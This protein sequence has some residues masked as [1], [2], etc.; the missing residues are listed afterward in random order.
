M[1]ETETEWLEI[2]K[3]VAPQGLHGEVRVLSASDFPERFLEPGQRWLRSPSQSQPQAIEL[4]KG[5][6]VPGK[7]LYVLQL[8]GVAN[9]NQAEAL[10]GSMLLVPASDR[11]PLDEGEFHVSD[12][13]GL[14]VIHHQT[15]AL[16]GTVV[17]VF[18]SSQDILEVQLAHPP[19]APRHKKKRRKQMAKPATVLIPFV[20]VIVPVVDLAQQRLE[21]LPPLGL[22]EDEPPDNAETP[23]D[24]QFDAT[25]VPVTESP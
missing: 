24:L 8:A 13:V 22:L 20:E 5:R 11:P 2:G 3:I 12:L 10:R 17:D 4:L 6:P 9:R 21:V 23:P 19:A 7:N 14:T 15:Q 18:A 25:T 16:I 1:S